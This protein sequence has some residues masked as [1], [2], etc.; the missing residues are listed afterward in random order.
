MP[1]PP[2]E[3]EDPEDGVWC[4]A[5]VV[6]V[7]AVATVLAMVGVPCGITAGQLRI[8]VGFIFAVLEVVV[9]RRTDDAIWEDA[10]V[11]VA[12]L[13]GNLYCPR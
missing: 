13:E 11:R 6:I 4:N 3:P 5:R 10:L 9:G 7:A 1:P 2:A 8:G 12:F